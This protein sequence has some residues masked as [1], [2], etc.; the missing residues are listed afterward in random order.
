MS[1]EHATLGSQSKG[2]EDVF[3]GRDRWDDPENSFIVAV[4]LMDSKTASGDS[5]SFPEC[6]N[7][8][9][10]RFFHFLESLDAIKNAQISR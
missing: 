5:K 9:K 8:L 3:L 4:Y 6:M 7:L 10:K 1:I 2:I